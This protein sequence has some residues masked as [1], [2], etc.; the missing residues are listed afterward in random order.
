M[1]TSHKG[2]RQRDDFKRSAESMD[3]EEIKQW[4]LDEKRQSYQAAFLRILRTIWAERSMPGEGPVRGI[5]AQGEIE[6]KP[7]DI[8]SLAVA[9]AQ[10]RTNTHRLVEYLQE[11]EVVE[12]R[13]NGRRMELYLTDKGWRQMK[14]LWDRVDPLIREFIDEFSGDLVRPSPDH[15]QTEAD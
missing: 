5:I 7:Y 2:D 9:L 12:K 14:D 13:K 10:P 8:S 11:Y 4:W 3:L 1:A 15:S 6:G